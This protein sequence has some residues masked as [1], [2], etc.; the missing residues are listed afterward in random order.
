[1]FHDYTG[2]AQYHKL[3]QTLFENC[4]R[5]KS[6]TAKDSDNERESHACR[7]VSAH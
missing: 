1:M 5:G 2:K 4:K 3:P 6:P 7:E